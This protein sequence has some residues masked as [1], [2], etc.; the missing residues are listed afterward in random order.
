MQRYLGADKEVDT[1]SLI[2]QLF[3]SSSP[4]PENH[5]IKERRFRHFSPFRRDVSSNCRDASLVERRKLQ[6][7]ARYPESGHARQ[8]TLF[9]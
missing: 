9:Q 8:D 6:F 1:P 7:K 3:E 4:Q 5:S 2:A